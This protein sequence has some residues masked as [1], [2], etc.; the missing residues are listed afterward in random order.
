MAT[1]YTKVRLSSGVK[2]VTILQPTALG[3]TVNTIRAPSKAD[4]EDGF[5]YSVIGQTG[6]VTKGVVEERLG[7]KKKQSKAL[8]PV[9][10]K[11]RKLLRMQQRAV[12]NY[13]VLHDRSSRKS[14]NGWAK[15]LGRNFI[16]AVRRS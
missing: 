3:V 11:L 16:K 9:D 1:V 13:L 8:R 14:K 12:G 10:R 5:T 6:R 2:R 4:A 15:D 7:D